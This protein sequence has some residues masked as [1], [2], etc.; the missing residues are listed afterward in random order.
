MNNIFINTYDVFTHT[1]I[2]LVPGA[3]VLVHFMSGVKRIVSPRDPHKKTHRNH[4]TRWFL[5]QI[6][7]AHDI[8]IYT[9]KAETIPQIQDID[10]Y[11]KQINK[12][13]VGKCRMKSDWAWRTLHE[14]LLIGTGRQEHDEMT[15]KS[16][17][18]CQIF[19]YNLLQRDGTTKRIHLSIPETSKTREHQP[20]DGDVAELGLLLWKIY[21]VC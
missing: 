6:Q 16:A 1:N 17:S 2:F 14:K 11:D 20:T 15:Y 21:P 19:A 9:S 7:N 12:K 13:N 10:F 4:K 8:R 5:L 3:L 18:Q